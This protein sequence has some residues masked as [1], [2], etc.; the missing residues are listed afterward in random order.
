MDEEIDYSSDDNVAPQQ[1]EE[2]EGEKN[3]PNYEDVNAVA[4]DT[5][6][7]LSHEENENA[8][9]LDENK[10]GECNDDSDDDIAEEF[11]T[12]EEEVENC[13]GSEDENGMSDELFKKVL[14]EL[15]TLKSRT[16]LKKNQS[17]V[18]PCAKN[19]LNLSISERSK[20]MTDNVRKNLL[21]ICD[22]VYRGKFPID[23]SIDNQ[24]YLKHLLDKR[25]PKE[26]VE[27]G[28]TEDLRTHSIIREVIDLIEKDGNRTRKNPRTR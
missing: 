12:E 26:D 28:L 4:N 6:N 3:E 18:I 1:E 11:G 9:E 10:A 7:D 22:F 16:E 24:R 19:F 14:S 27:V 13:E 21:H 5:E 15:I 20:K 23:I 17:K 25:T 2:E 8:T